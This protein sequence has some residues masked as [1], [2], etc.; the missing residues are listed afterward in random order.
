M[1]KWL[2]MKT[3]KSVE[4]Q[5]PVSPKP[6]LV[7]Q[8]PGGK[9]RTY[10]PK[11]FPA[12]R[13]SRIKAVSAFQ[14]GFERLEEM[15]ALMQNSAIWSLNRERPPLPL[16]LP[17]VVYLSK[18]IHSQLCLTNNAILEMMENHGLVRMI[19]DK[20]ARTPRSVLE[21]HCSLLCSI[22]IFLFVLVLLF[23]LLVPFNYVSLLCFVF[24]SSF[25]Y[26][27]QLMKF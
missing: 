1:L 22:L 16:P 25:S 14:N 10:S 7:S 15:D 19:V 17:A 23:F 20:E 18:A 12:S 3:K 13:S 21:K 24:R 11:T 2:D 8:S 26:G 9:K 4:T 27:E 6:T 5:S